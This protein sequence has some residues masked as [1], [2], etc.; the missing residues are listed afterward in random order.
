MVTK[1]LR[2]R[3]EIVRIVLAGSEVEYVLFFFSLSEIFFEF[4]IGNL[5]HINTYHNPV[6]KSFAAKKFIRFS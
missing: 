3:G 6:P 4:E 2:E 5:L 1:I